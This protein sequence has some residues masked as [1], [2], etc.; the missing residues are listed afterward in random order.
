MLGGRV[1]WGGVGGEFFALFPPSIINL[2]FVAFMIVLLVPFGYLAGLFTRVTKELSLPITFQD[3]AFLI[4]GL[5][6]L[7]YC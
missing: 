7:T 2:I 6:I 1:E 5:D 3:L 4:W